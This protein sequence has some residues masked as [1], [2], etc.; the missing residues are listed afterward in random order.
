MKQKQK[1]SL[2]LKGLL[3]S[4]I[5]AIAVCIILMSIYYIAGEENTKRG[6]IP[7]SIISGL[8]A[9]KIYLKKKLK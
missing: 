5:V 1:N 3:I 2:N 7:L 4:I 6:I 9:S 8:A